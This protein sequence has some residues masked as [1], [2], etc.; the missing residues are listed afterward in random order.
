MYDELSPASM[1]KVCGFESVRWMS[2]LILSLKLVKLPCDGGLHDMTAVLPL[3]T[4]TERFD[5]GSGTAKNPKLVVWRILC[6][7]ILS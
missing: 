1:V 2:G 5:G 3:R 4:D 6:V 7:L